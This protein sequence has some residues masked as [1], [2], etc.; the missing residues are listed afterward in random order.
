MSF[1]VNWGNVQGDGTLNK[2]LR[3]WV[4]HRL[5]FLELPD[6]LDNL[7][8]VDFQLGDKPPDITI[9]DIDK[10]FKEFY[11]SEDKGE[12]ED[13]AAAAAAAAPPLPAY[14]P[15]VS[16]VPNSRPTSPPPKHFQP[17]PPHQPFPFRRANT[18]PTN[19]MSVGISGMIRDEEDSTTDL[20]RNMTLNSPK[21]AKPQPPPPGLGPP[22]DE[23]SM[24]VQLST[25][26]K[27]DSN[28][29]IEIKCDLIVNYPSPKF[30]TLPV[31]LKIT[32][33]QIH[34]LLVVAHI[35]K[36][37]YLSFLC[38]IEDEDDIPEAEDEDDNSDGESRQNSRFTGVKPRRSKERID[39]IKD[40]NIEGELGSED[41]VS[42]PATDNE[43]LILK[44]IGKI[45]TFLIN[46]FR[47]ILIEELAWPNWIELDFTEDES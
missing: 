5:A 24:D 38:D 31:R 7:Q 22:P 42:W 11:V 45:E 20:L 25:D 35:S 21:L 32:N 26:I 29:Y 30:I 34:T 41:G 39:I 16:S 8:V 23:G 15:T 14:F 9:R 27:W 6:F 46:S 33:M 43:A 28:I 44:S 10:P 3:E 47:A 18:G 17:P 13:H 2:Q 4:N 37:V 36:H 12:N 1:V 40:M 19:V